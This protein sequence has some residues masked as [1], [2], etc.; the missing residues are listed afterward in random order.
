MMPFYIS[1]AKSV[2]DLVYALHLLRKYFHPYEM[3]ASNEFIYYAENYSKLFPGEDYFVY[4]IKTPMTDTVIGMFSGVKLNEFITVDYLVIEQESRWFYKLAL[5]EILKVLKEFE[6]PIIIEAETPE[7]VRLYKM[8]GFVQFENDYTYHMLGVNLQKKT[9]TV[10]SH[11]SHLMYLSETPLDFKT[12]RDT[13]YNKHYR[14]WNAIYGTELTE[15]YNKTLDS[16]M[17]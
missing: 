9:S 15:K 7:L 4:A 1:R 16:Y 17:I 6:R 14:R 3:V 13:L 11:Q 12:T 8:G 2:D 5:K 10:M